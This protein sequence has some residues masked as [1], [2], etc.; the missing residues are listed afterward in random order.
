MKIVVATTRNHLG[1]YT[2]LKGLLHAITGATP[3]NH[4]GYYTQLKGLLHAITGATTFN[5]QGYY[6]QLPG[7]LHA[8]TG[9]T[10]RNYRGYYTQLPGLL[11]AITW[12]TTRT[13]RS[14]YTRG[15][16]VSPSCVLMNTCSRRIIDRTNIEQQLSHAEIQSRRFFDMQKS[17]YTEIQSCGIQPHKKLISRNCQSAETMLRANRKLTMMK[18]RQAKVLLRR[19]NFSVA[20]F[21]EY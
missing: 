1:Y 10:T 5:H 2:Q 12:A 16:V 3:R 8:I 6:T 14:Y 17:L 7:L 18:F 19:G 4:Q 21:P 13:S 20:D 15:C 9:A 11:H